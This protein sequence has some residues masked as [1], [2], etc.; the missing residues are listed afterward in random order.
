MTRRIVLSSL[1]TVVLLLIVATGAFWWISRSGMPRRSGAAALDGLVSSV[2]IR[3]NDWGV[4]HVSAATAVDLATA[5]GYL[6]AND[7]LVQL[8][9]GRRL[10]AGRLAEVV[11]PAALPSD[12]YFRSLGM[13]RL[14]A[15]MLEAASPETRTM[16]DGYARGVNAWLR[17]RGSDLPP[18]LRLLGVDPAPWEPIH[19]LYF[20]LQMAHELSF[21]QGRPEEDRYEWLRA[22]GR[23]RLADLLGEPDLLVAES[24]VALAQQASPAVVKAAGQASLDDRGPAVGPLFGSP[25]SNGWALGGSR[26]ASGHPLVANDPHLPLSLPGYWYQVVLRAPDYEAA[27]MTLPGFPFVVIGRGE[28]LAWALTNVMLDDHDIFFERLSADGSSVQRGEGWLPLETVE[29]RIAVAG[30]DAV[31]LTV[32]YSDIGVVLEADAERGLP[33]RSMA[34]TGGMPADP[35]AAFLLLARSQAVDDL[36]GQLDSYVAP[37]QNLVAADRDNGLLYTALG[38][39]PARRGGDGRLPAPAWDVEYGWNGLLPQ[40]DNPTI[41]R[42][43]ADLIITA[44]HDIRPGTDSSLTAPFTADFDTPHRAERIRQLL[45]RHDRWTADDMQGLQSDISSR[46]A[47][48]LVQLLR[49][50]YTGGA[51]TAYELLASWDGAMAMHGPGA[52]FLILERELT[53]G[54]FGDEAGAHRLR[55][56]GGRAEILRALRGDLSAEWFDDVGTSGLETRHDVTAAALERAWQEA[57]T[58]W[59]EQPDDWSYAELHYLWL[60]NPAGTVPVI[61]GWFDRGPIPLPGSA[62]TVAA[63]G[64]FW[65]DGNQNVAYGPSMRWVADLDDPD[66][67]LAVLPAG[68]SGHPADRHYDDQLAG[69]L[70][71]T[72][73]PIHWSEAVI[74]ANTVSTLTLRPTAESITR[75]AVNR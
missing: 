60:R 16:L 21:W 1:L 52:L 69:Y 47:L 17:E 20:Q 43:D 32:R 67:S 48:E 61:G 44:N 41:L 10:A 31:S 28:R 30:A 15:A 53:A 39:V 13:P 40:A 33:A 70:S 49:D 75:Q 26:T 35:P 58:R 66:R 14:A 24:I 12:R 38:R 4:P 50:D 62:T 34:W 65:L 71:G 63:F 57:T 56:I 25:G 51:A 9:L 74:A 18:E 6:H 45:E 46:Y 55:Q 27:G 73:H 37:A 3:F 68:Q 8:E 54:T 5:I 36:I 19:S 42:P 2:T 22:Y 59:G 72:L 11:G 7:R 29:E 23:E 64:G